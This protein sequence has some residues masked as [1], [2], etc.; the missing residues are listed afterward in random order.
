MKN[1]HTPAAALAASL[2]SAL[3]SAQ[4][5]TE[6]AA[7]TVATNFV[8]FDTLPLGPTSVAA[9]QAA[10]ANSLANLTFT[11]STAAAG[12]YNTNAAQQAL[13]QVAGV[14]EIIGNGASFD[15]TNL[16]IDFTGP[17]TEVGFGIGDWN[18]PV[19]ID[20]YLAGTQQT[21][22]TSSA[23]SSS[24]LFKYYQMS[25]GAFDRIDIRA[26]TSGGNWTLIDLE[27]QQLS[28]LFA[29]FSATP[30]SGASPLTVQFTDSSFSSDP[31]GVLAWEWDFESDGVIDSLQQNPTHTYTGCG[32]F[33]V[34]LRVTDAS[35]PQ[36]TITQVGLINVGALAASFTTSQIAPGVWQFTDTSTG[37]PTTWAW[38][39]DGDGNVDD[40]NQNPV[41]AATTSD[42]CLS[43][44]N[45]TLA[46][47][48]AC[49]TDSTTQP[50]FD[51]G[52]ATLGLGETG[53]G[54]GTSSATAVGNYF[55]VQVTNPE[56]I[57]IC[58]LQ[59][60]PYSFTGPFTA[61]VYITDG[62]HV[63]K[64]GVPS[65][66]VL[67]ATGSGEGVGGAFNPPTLADVVLDNSFFLPAGDYGMA[68]YISRPGGGSVN[69]AY[70]NGPAAAPYVTPDFT[71]H[72]NGV[73][74]S[75]TS[76]LGP[77]AFQPRLW[78]GGFYYTTCSTVNVSAAGSYGPGCSNS[79][80]VVPSITT[81]S[82][83]T[84]G[85]TFA[86][87]LDAGLAAPAATVMIAGLS[88]SVYN[89]LPL[90]LDLGLLGAPGCDLRTSVDVTSVV[91]A[92]PG[93]PNPWSL[94]I[95]NQANLACVT[96]YNQ[97]AVLDPTA[98]NF[99]FVL[100]NAIAAQIGN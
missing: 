15:A 96:F 35:H 13:A 77:C 74:C 76:E 53:G 30:T 86:M 7:P 59:A 99:G 6:I 54:N 46:I 97:L 88:K 61:N 82:P 79:A 55:D 81:T 10:G 38:D 40:A 23:Y 70:T 36:S 11:A 12:V 50:V 32:P 21:S 95:P 14:P 63:G 5:V 27:T 98:N 80:G 94:P 84:I 31:L 22:F 91:I 3:A 75:S 93:A 87:N 85:G 29:S 66:W 71:L 20:F 28:G 44:P 41:Y 60:T 48:N 69:I 89:G 2:L 83:P 90:P 51:P 24:A 37:G 42:P 47:A 17:C 64:E 73:G 100:S 39:F 1:M 68:F 9:L 26:S 18:G 65:E 8:D 58:A 92:N 19:I 4:T 16:Q 72:P 43:L 78:N 57:R 45:C 52:A 56:G 49:S 25:G 34:T 67:V 33:D 62:T